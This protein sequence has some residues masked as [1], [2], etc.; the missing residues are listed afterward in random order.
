MKDEGCAATLPA[1]VSPRRPN[2]VTVRPIGLLDRGIVTALE[3]AAHG[4]LID[5]S[6]QVAL[7]PDDAT[8]LSTWCRTVAPSV[9]PAHAA[10][11]LVAADTIDAAK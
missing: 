4:P 3:T 6:Y 5:G 10:V 11:L 2:S 1:G 7:Q 9:S 8:A